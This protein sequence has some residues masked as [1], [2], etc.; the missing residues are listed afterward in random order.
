VHR[1]HPL[2]WLW[3]SLA[4]GW[5]GFIAVVL[6]RADE[7][8]LYGTFA[9]A[10]GALAVHLW[11]TTR[12]RRVALHENAVV[13]GDASGPRTVYF[14]DVVEVELLYLPKRWSDE[15]IAAI[16]LCEAERRTTLPCELSNFEALI[17]AV[18][19]RCDAPKSARRIGALSERP[20]D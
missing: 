15:N 5:L 11:R 10:A 6:A 19:T 18:R 3:A 13:V 20:N 16:V 1:V 8:W 12:R 14:P 9:V 2:G 17:Q 7:P 4:A